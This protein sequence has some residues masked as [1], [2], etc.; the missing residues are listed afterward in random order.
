M[1][2]SVL[3]QLG[4]SEKEI[5]IYLIVLQQGKVALPDVAQLS[6]INRTT[7]YSVAKELIKKGVIREEIGKKTYLI[8][9]PPHDLDTLI[10]QDRLQLNKKEHLM[11]SA[12]T[13]LMPFVQNMRYTIPRIT[14][15]EEEKVEK[16]MYA[17]SERWSQSIRDTKSMWVG[18]QDNS[19]VEDYVS[20]VDWYWTR[21]FSKDIQLQL[22]TNDSAVETEMKKKKFDRRQMQWWGEENPITSTLWVCGEY[23][24]MIVT[25]TH[26]HYLVEIHDKLLAFNLHE[27]FQRL[28]K[29]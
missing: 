4:F 17:E 24:I 23:V 26:P 27:T 15:V 9:R 11:E 7:V 29:K 13:E 14:F 28:W 22:F 16:H 20:W 8:A 6:G 19:F 21:D 10:E 12:I 25:R 3:A 1:I 2:Q 18:F 5:R